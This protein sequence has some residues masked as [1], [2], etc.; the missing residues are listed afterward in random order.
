MTDEY[1]VEDYVYIAGGDP[2][3]EL[4]GCTCNNLDHSDYDERCPANGFPI[5]DLFPEGATIIFTCW[6][7]G[8]ISNSEIGHSIGYCSQECFEGEKKEEEKNE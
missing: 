5:T 3:D 8:T 6:E 2:E 7:C 1:N 4:Y